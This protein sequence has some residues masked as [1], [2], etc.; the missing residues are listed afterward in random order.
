[1]IRKLYIWIVCITLPNLFFAQSFKLIEDKPN[2]INVLFSFSEKQ[3]HFK[4]LNG[5]SY[6]DFTKSYSIVNQSKGSPCLPLFSQ[7]VILPN[8]G[9]AKININYGPYQE[10]KDITILPCQDPKK[11]DTT[12]SIYK[13]ETFTKN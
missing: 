12:L 8:K 7:S 6:L 5:V 11:R 4:H 2:T 1:M 10:Y 13:S 9:E 3:F